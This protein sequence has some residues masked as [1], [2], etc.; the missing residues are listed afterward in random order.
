MLNE[1]IKKQ[2][3]EKIEE[4][5][6]DVS[7]LDSYHWD[8]NPYDVEPALAWGSACGVW[9]EDEEYSEQCRTLAEWVRADGLGAYVDLADDEDE[10]GQMSLEA[11]NWLMNL[12][13]S[14]WI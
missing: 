4:V 9:N 7:E 8:N 1:T 12:I 3:K 11:Y 6:I 5:E 14:G 13:G 10:D 2:L